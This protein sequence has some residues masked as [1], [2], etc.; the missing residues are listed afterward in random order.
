MSF[1]HVCVS[2]VKTVLLS[3]KHIGGQSCFMTPCEALLKKFVEIGI[4]DSEELPSSE[5]FVLC[6]DISKVLSFKSTAICD[7]DLCI[8]LLDALDDFSLKSCFWGSW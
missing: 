5:I 1:L 7:Y 4:S 3:S 8:Y 6:E 2:N